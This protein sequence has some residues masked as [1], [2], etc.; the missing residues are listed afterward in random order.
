MS[1]WGVW[2]A[3]Y[4]LEVLAADKWELR[5][6]LTGVMFQASTAHEPPYVDVVFVRENNDYFPPGYQAGAGLF[7]LSHT[8]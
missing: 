8:T 6:D 1:R 5:K 3:D 7:N 2:R 4:G